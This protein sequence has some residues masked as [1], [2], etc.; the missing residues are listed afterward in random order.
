MFFFQFLLTNLVESEPGKYKWR[1][2]LPVLEDSFA[3]RIAVFPN[4]K[5]RTYNG[6]TLFIAGTESD[7]IKKSDHP[8]IKKI[9]P[10]AKFHYITGAGHW[11]HA[12]KPAEFLDTLTLFVN[13]KH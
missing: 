10:L 9:F 5:G 8:H 4:E 7:Y 6:P 2:N 12:D 3:T 11:V 13:E 1:I